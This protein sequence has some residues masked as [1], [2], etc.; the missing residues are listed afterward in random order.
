MRPKERISLRMM[1]L[2]IQQ[3]PAVG[4]LGLAMRMADH[5][6]GVTEQQCREAMFKVT[7]DIYAEYK[8][9]EVTK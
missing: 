1:H 7:Q 5:L 9:M 8:E 6:E 3:A 2:V 4:L